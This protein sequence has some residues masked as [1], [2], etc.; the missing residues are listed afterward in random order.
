MLQKH[1]QLALRKYFKVDRRHGKRPLPME[2]SPPKSG[3]GDHTSAVSFGTTAAYEQDH[4]H[5]PTAAETT[6][7]GKNI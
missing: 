7:Q 3:G 2:A 4:S 1:T 5:P 6:A